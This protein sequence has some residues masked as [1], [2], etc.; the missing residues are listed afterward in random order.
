MS[1]IGN[2]GTPY[3]RFAYY[4]NNVTDTMAI[5]VTMPVAGTI[6][7]VSAYFAGHGQTITAR[8]CVWNASRVLVA[9]S[10]DLSVGSG[11][12]GLGGQSFQTGT[13]TS[14]YAAANGEVLYIGFWRHANQSHEWTEQ[15][16]STEFQYASL[17]NTNPPSGQTWGTASG[18]PSFYATYT[19][20]GGGPALVSLRRSG[21]WGTHPF[22]LRRSGAWA[23]PHSYI[24]RG[25]VWVQVS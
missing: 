5:Q 17:S 23:T 19:T 3:Q 11:T 7:S 2:T 6:T 10:A 12:G 20:G 15:N 24:R 1:T 14:A 18:N 13:M 22:Q 4:L 16:G 21:A 9:Q 8:T 25:G